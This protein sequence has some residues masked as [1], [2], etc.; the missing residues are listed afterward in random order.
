MPDVFERY[1]KDFGADVNEEMN[2][3]R[4]DPSYTVWFE[5]GPLEIPADSMPWPRCSS[6]LSPA[7][8]KSSKTSWPKPR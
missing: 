5:D 3:V 4:L 1:F 8:A 7:Q 6:R 2:L